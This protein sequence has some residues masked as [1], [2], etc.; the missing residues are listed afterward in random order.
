MELIPAHDPTG[1]TAK[2]ANRIVAQML[3]GLSMHKAG[4]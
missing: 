3:T 4:K 2:A 1:I